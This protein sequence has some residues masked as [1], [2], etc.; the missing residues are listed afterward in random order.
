MTT[1]VTIKNHGPQII[2]IETV[3][4]AN[5]KTGD[6]EI[7]SVIYEIYPDQENTLYLWQHHSLKINECGFPPSEDSA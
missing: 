6:G 5:T 1:S 4:L 3:E 2:E 7:V